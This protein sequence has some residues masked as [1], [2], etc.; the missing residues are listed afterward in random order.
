MNQFTKNL[1]YLLAQK[2]FT[3]KSLGESIGAA[4]TTISSY[5]AGKAEPNIDRLLAISEFFDVPIE[6]LI[7]ADLSTRSYILHEAKDHSLNEPSVHYIRDITASGGHLGGMSSATQDVVALNIP[8]AFKNS[9]AIQVVGD[10]M[11]PIICDGDIAI[12][13]PILAKSF[14]EGRIYIIETNLDGV[15]VKYVYRVNDN[16]MRFSSTNA[17]MYPDK[18]YPMASIRRL[19]LVYKKMTNV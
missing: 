19:Y 8:G 1:N 2:K 12:A 15:T 6:Q 10:S 5:R 9:I 7:N 14:I 4:S 3:N 11:A 18:E 16:T 17:Q 13:R